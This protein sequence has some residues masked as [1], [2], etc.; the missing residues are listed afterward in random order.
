LDSN[1]KKL[2]EST[3]N[4]CRPASITTYQLIMSSSIYLP[5]SA[6]DTDA[7]VVANFNQLTELIHSDVTA[8]VHQHH[9][10][11]AHHNSNAATAQHSLVE[12]LE[13]AIA[14]D[15]RGSASSS[16]RSVLYSAAAAETTSPL[17]PPRRVVHA[18]GLGGALTGSSSVTRTSPVVVGE[19]VC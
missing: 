7:A 17:P 11:H 4:H 12:G 19:C 6:M 8:A 18:L 14:G 1:N 15:S 13:L 9:H 3:T 2:F 10:L 16:P 5:V